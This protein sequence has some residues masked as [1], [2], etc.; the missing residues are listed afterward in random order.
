MD[1]MI[2]I[3]GSFHMMQKHVKVKFV[4]AYL[5]ITRDQ[6]LLAPWLKVLINWIGNALMRR[7]RALYFPM[8]FRH[9]L[10]MKDRLEYGF[11][12]EAIYF[13]TRR[14]TP[15]EKYWKFWFDNSI[16]IKNIFRPNQMVLGLHN[17]WTNQ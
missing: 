9:Y 3:L 17:S 8:V 6:K 14:M 5:K 7:K 13:T 4:L 15:E 2:E 1:K 12:P 10:T 11:I 16:D